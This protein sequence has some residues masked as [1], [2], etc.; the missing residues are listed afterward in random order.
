MVK[1]PLVK[2]EPLAHSAKSSTEWDESYYFVFFD[3]TQNLGCMTRLGFKPNKDEG[4][5]FFILFFPDGSAG[6][7]QN[8]KRIDDNTRKKKLQAGQVIHQPRLDGEWKYQLQANITITRRPE[9]LGNID[10]HPE[11]VSKVM[12]ISINVTFSPLNDAYE[13]GQN[14]SQ[15][16]R[17]IGKK[18]AD[19]HWGQTGKVKGQ[20]KLGDKVFSLEEAMGQRDHTHGLR[21]WTGIASWLYYAVWF[22]EKLCINSAALVTEDGEISSGGF[23]FKNGKNIPIKSIR[24]LDQE[25]QGDVFPVSSKLELVDEFDGTHVLEGRAG[26]VVP[27][28]FIDKEDNTSILAQSFGNFTFDSLTEGYGYFETL[29]RTQPNKRTRAGKK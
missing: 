7:Y 11:L 21:E 23:I 4:M 3:R 18:V 22:S 12:P 29:R 20:I 17:E 9:D 27:V 8:M 24:I 2:T 5:A 19:A 6:S 25:F 14:M 10:Q 16:S 1:E 26:S 13:Y 15:K 28:P